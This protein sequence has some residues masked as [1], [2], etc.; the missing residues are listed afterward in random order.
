MLNILGDLLE[1]LI[2]WVPAWADQMHR[3]GIFRSAHS[4]NVEVMHHGHVW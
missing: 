2:A 3:Q 1:K 4:P